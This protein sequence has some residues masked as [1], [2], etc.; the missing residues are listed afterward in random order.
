MEVHRAQGLN[1]S[2]T[3]LTH[4]RLCSGIRRRGFAW[5]KACAP[6]TLW[7]GCGS[8]AAE[9]LS[10][11]CGTLDAGSRAHHCCRNTKTKDVSWAYVRLLRPVRTNNK[12][13]TWSPFQRVLLP[14]CPV[15]AAGSC[16]RPLFGAAVRSQGKDAVAEPPRGSRFSSAS[17][18]HPFPRNL[19][20]FKIRN[21]PIQTPQ[22]SLGCSSQNR[23]CSGLQ[24]AKKI[25]F[26]VPRVV[27]KG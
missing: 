24:T 3:A 16:C 5:T 12:D 1:S 7:Q 25:H 22:T 27:L 23:G 21:G 17:S 14:P 8:G 26:P 15:T 10:S 4:P 13:A 9:D 6:S 20:I 11:S 19:L 2:L 18:S